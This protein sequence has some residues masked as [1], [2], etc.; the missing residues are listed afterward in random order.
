MDAESSSPVVYFNDFRSD[1]EM[2]GAPDTAAEE[3][4]GE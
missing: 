3:L 2:T 1:T 4:S